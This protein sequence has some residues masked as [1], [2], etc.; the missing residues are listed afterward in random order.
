MIM[1]SFDILINEPADETS[2]HIGRINIILRLFYLKKGKKRLEYT[3]SYCS[4]TALCF[5]LFT[6]VIII[7]LKE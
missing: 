4:C 6:K 3:N 2:D 7:A 5:L 1:Q